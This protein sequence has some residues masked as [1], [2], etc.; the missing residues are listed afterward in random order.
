M[1]VLLSYSGGKRRGAI[2]DIEALSLKVARLAYKA[3]GVKPAAGAEIG[4]L[5]T[6]DKEIRALNKQ[7]R[8]ID[9]AT[10]VLSFETGDELMPGDI[11]LSLD[12]LRREAEAEGKDS[13]AHCAHLLAHGV[14]HLL[15]F[16][17]ASDDE[18]EEM[19]ALEAKILGE[20]GFQI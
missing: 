14:L 18:A 19:E 17:H 6:G 11:S 16:D 12:T 3:A 4:V 13:R 2:A 7:W 8:G 1:K 15:G 5:L 20:L 9:R 10:N